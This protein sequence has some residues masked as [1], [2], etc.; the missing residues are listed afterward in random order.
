MFP[1]L[2]ALLITG[3]IIAKFTRF[4]KFC[5]RAFPEFAAALRSFHR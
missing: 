4:L 2:H 5:S 3:M 1:Y